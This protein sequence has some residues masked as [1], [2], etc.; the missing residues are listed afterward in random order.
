MPSTDNNKSL[1][2]AVTSIHLNDSDND[3]LLPTE[4]GAA[5][6]KLTDIPENGTYRYDMAF[7][8]FKGASR[9]EKVTIIINGDSIKVVYEGDGKLKTPRGTIIDQG[10]I[11]KHKSGVY[12]ISKNTNDA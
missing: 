11:I 9:G 3:T 2:T 10:K 4:A 7:A 8:E 6:K 1:D 12:I 5:R